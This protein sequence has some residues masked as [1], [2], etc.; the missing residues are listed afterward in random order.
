MNTFTEQQEEL[1]QYLKGVGYGWGKF[2]QSVERQGWCS[3]KQ[4]QVMKRMKQKVKDHRPSR[5][6]YAHVGDI[7]DLHDF[8]FGGH[9]GQF[10]GELA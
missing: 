9:P 10:D 7:A 3:P 4:E 8:G 1:I 2:A 6:M 5:G